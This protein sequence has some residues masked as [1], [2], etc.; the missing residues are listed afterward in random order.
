[1]NLH[2]AK[3][4]EADV[5]FLADPL[6]AFPLHVDVRIVRDG[7]MGDHEGPRAAKGYFE[8]V[9]EMRNG[10]GT[11]VIAAP[12]NWSALA[13][14]E[15]KYREAEMDRLLYVAATRAREMLVVGRC[16]KA[17][18][19]KKGAWAVLTSAMADAPSLDVPASAPAPVPEPV[20]LSAAAAA[21]ARAAAEQQHAAVRQPSWSAASVT[22]ETKHLPRLVPDA[23]DELDPADPTR[24]V[25]QDRPSHRADAGLAWGTLIHGLLEH[26]M[27]HPGATTA[28][29]HRLAR[30]LTLDDRQ[31]RPVI[32][33]A[34]QTVE[35]L[36]TSDFWRR[37]RSAPEH[38]AEVPFAVV[39][40]SRSMP[41]L[42]NGVI[43]LICQAGPEWA[44]VDYKTD[45]GVDDA[46]LMA[47]YQAQI[48]AYAAA[49]TRVTAAPARSTIVHVRQEDVAGDEVPA[50]DR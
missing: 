1:M 18:D 44:I 31:L 21:A 35:A 24:A 16:A 8:V 27:R 43:D 32:E 23:A 30:W 20:D 39:D 41:E 37:A 10:Y 19:A 6:R 15:M 7:G 36:A 11:R 29:L 9:E 34:V 45:A 49:W 50:G 28:D 14:E 25:V 26:A 38:H 3:G 40:R 48:D 42:L 22:A 17:A 2:K 13:D 12:A 5:V 33:R 4:L 47:R 46:E